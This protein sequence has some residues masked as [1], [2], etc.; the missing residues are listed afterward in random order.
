MRRIATWTAAA[1]LTVG[2]LVGCSDG[3]YDAG[4]DQPTG[5][6]TAPVPSTDLPTGLPTATPSETDPETPETPTEAAGG[7][8]CDLLRDAQDSFETLDPTDFEATVETFRT[9]AAAA[10]PEVSAEWGQL[11]GVLDEFTSAL[12]DAG[13]SFEDFSDPDALATLDPETLER[14]GSLAEGLDEGM[15]TATDTIEEHAL[16]ECGVDLNA[17]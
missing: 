10:P 4:G 17:S 6:P 1:V 14:I 2:A 16:S 15:Q 7:D 12:E 3:E 5:L 9:I 8:Y 13:L 11:V